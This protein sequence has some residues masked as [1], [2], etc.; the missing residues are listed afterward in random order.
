MQII[1]LIQPNQIYFVEAASLPLAGASALQALE[2]H[3]QI[4]PDQKILIHGGAGGIGSLA[5][6][7]A[8]S[9]GAFVAATAS[10][11]DI[12]YV[13]SLGADKVIDFRSEKFEDIL[14]NY[15][16]VFDT[17]SGDTTNRSFKGAEKR[18]DYCKYAGAP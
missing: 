7:I 18:G 17:F 16:A 1:Q 4:K 14:K 11:N 6:Q 3:I 5:V 9:H 10:A 12:N 13:L 15:D 2:G 8:K